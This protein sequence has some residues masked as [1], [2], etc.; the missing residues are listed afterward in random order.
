MQSQYVSFPILSV[1]YVLTVLASWDSGENVW[2]KLWQRYAQ[3][4]NFRKLSFTYSRNSTNHFPIGPK[5]DLQQNTCLTSTKTFLGLRKLNYIGFCVLGARCTAYWL[6]W[7]WPVSFKGLYPQNKH[8]R[9]IHKAFNMS[10]ELCCLRAVFIT[11]FR[12]TYGARTQSSVYIKSF[13][14][15]K[16]FGSK[17]PLYSIPTSVIL[18]EQL[19]QICG[20]RRMFSIS[21]PITHA[22]TGNHAF[23][24]VTLHFWNADH[25]LIQTSPVPVFKCCAYRQLLEKF[26]NL[27]IV[28]SQS[29]KRTLEA[30]ILKE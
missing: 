13:S 24:S 8:A 18:T 7:C 30:V 19:D 29:T 22:V 11:H 17:R 9:I 14:H 15:E 16:I 3:S 27:T 26:S 10:C 6:F 23:N 4:F 5:T 1:R 21:V 2:I 28:V 20:R 25:S 12:C